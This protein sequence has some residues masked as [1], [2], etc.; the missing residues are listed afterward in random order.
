MR[1]T[2]FSF[3]RSVCVGLIVAARLAG[4]HSK[5]QEA[6]FARSFCLNPLIAYAGLV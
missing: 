4:N 1:A 3:C 6:R 5:I 2:V